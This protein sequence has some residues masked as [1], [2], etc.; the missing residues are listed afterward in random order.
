MDKSILTQHIAR[1]R[2]VLDELGAACEKDFSYWVDLSARALSQ[3]KT[4]FFF[5]NGGSASD[6][7]HLA[8]EFVVRFQDNRPAWPALALGTDTSMVTAI[9]NDLGFE[10]LFSRQIEALGRPEDLA[11]GISTSGTS[12]NVLKG[13]NQA[14]HQ[15][16]RT[17]LLTSQRCV[18][19]S[20]TIDVVLRVPSMETA[21]I[22]EMHILLGHSLCEALE[23]QYK[24]KTMT[25]T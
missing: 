23:V 24:E 17:I 12:P 19:H 13:L 4:C 7:Q 5:G 8:T 25:S 11:I 18:T 15:K 16:M 14:H 3:G 1:H 2:G 10:N 22:Q 21:L 9:G 20:E 6:A